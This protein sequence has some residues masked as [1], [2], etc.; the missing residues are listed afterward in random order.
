MTGVGVDRDRRAMGAGGPTVISSCLV[1]APVAAPFVALTVRKM[2]PWT[3]GTV[4]ENVV[5]PVRSVVPVAVVSETPFGRVADSV[6]VA[7]DAGA[8]LWDT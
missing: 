7:F 6:T 4:H 3:T 2:L 1:D 5:D 8:P